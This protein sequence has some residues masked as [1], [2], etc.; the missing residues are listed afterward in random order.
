M[1]HRNTGLLQ[2]SIRLCCL[3]IYRAQ[4]PDGCPQRTRHG[5]ESLCASEALPRRQQRYPPLR[6]ALPSPHSS[7]N[8]CARPMPSATLCLSLEVPVLAGCGEPLLGIA[9]SRRYYCNLCIGAWIHA[10]QCSPGAFARYYPR[11]NGLT[12]RM[13]GSAHW[14][15][16]AMQLQQGER[17]RGCNHS[18]MFR[19]PCSLGLP[20][21]PTAEAHRL[22]GGQ[23]VYTTQCPFGYPH[24]LWYRYAS[25]PSN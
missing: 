6:P 2:R 12:S 5:R 8:S 4:S 18:L 24:R 3:P 23:A 14:I 1:H 20:V 22:Q 11:D 16:P 15:L 13:T 9:P 21:A 25:V 10:P 19:L 17:F 7:T